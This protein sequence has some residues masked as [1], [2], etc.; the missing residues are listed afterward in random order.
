MQRHCAKHCLSEGQSTISK[1]QSHCTSQ[2]P[3]QLCNS[4]AKSITC[5]SASP[6]PLLMQG[7]GFIRCHYHTL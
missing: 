1:E 3:L 2:P 5:A 4:T 6:V 7:F